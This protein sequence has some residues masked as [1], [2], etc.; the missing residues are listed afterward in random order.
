MMKRKHYR[1]RW[2]SGLS[3]LAMAIVVSGCATS[4]YHARQAAV[5]EQPGYSQSNNAELANSGI[6]NHRYGYQFYR[7]GRGHGH[8]PGRGYER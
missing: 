4:G 7:H 3:L 2:V 6:R 8:G 1:R 5:G